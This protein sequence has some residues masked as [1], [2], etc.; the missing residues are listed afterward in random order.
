VTTVFRP[1]REKLDVMGMNELGERSNATPA[2]SD[3][4]IFLRTDRHLN[5]VAED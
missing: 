1:D 4:E 5:C 2:I 3:G